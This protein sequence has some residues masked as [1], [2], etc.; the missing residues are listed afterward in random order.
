MN[1]A[2][3]FVVVWCYTG[4][5]ASMLS[6]VAASFV[7]VWCYTGESASMP[8]PVAASFVVVWYYTGQSASMP[9][10]VAASFVVVWYYT[11]E[12]ASM[13]SPVAALFVVVWYYTGE[14]ASMPSLVAA[15]APVFAATGLIAVDPSD[16]MPPH[17][18]Q[19]QPWKALG[20]CGQGDGNVVIWCVSKSVRITIDLLH[21]KEIHRDVLNSAPIVRLARRLTFNRIY[22]IIPLRGLLYA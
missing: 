15:G 11:G 4:E 7:V 1:R 3:S 22:K 14:S 6:P 19:C 20:C 12:S 9:S 18:V 17:W 8:S 2:A 21:A 5:S 13:P 16:A 10:P